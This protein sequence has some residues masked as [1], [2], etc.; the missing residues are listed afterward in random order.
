MP[1]LRIKDLAQFRTVVGSNAGLVITDAARPPTF[2][3]NPRDCPGIRE[4]YYFTKVIE[5]GEATGGY[6][7][8]ASQE[9]ASAHW[10]NA[11]RCGTAAC[12]SDAPEGRRSRLEGVALLGH[13][14]KATGAGRIRHR[15]DPP[16]GAEA[17]MDDW[18]TTQR[19][20]LGED[21]EDFVLTTWPA[22]LKGQALAVYGTAV[23][24]AI[25]DLV[26]GPG[27]WMGEPSP[28]LAFNGA[29]LD[30]RFYFRCRLSLPD[31]VARW[32]EDEILAEVRARPAASVRGELWPW[33]CE[34]GFADP[35]EGASG[36]GLDRYIEA[37]ERRRSDAL[38][39]PGIRLWQVCGGDDPDSL[40]DAI[41]EAVFELAIALGENVPGRIAGR[42]G[43]RRP[44]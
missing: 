24:A 34:E 33:L 9:A 30:D 4:H 40:R 43:P 26:D 1:P 39:R 38:L 32:S 13:L 21:D 35:D 16:P 8:V 25:V 18:T 29:G 2:H 11:V 44:S 3:A 12:R 17:M 10:P 19:I 31:Y 27:A 5:N 15:T 41:S 14:L 20:A 23:G 7:F 28:H 37:L 36:A 22:E 6:F 42:Q